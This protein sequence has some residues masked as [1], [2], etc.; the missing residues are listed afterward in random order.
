MSELVPVSAGADLALLAQDELAAAT[1]LAQNSIAESSKKVYDRDMKLFREWCTAR[2]LTALPADVTTVARYVAAMEATLAVS[3]IRR[4]LASISVHHQAAGHPTPTRDPAIGRVMDGLV[5]RHG[6]APKKVRAARTSVLR[7]LVA[8]LH[9]D[10][11]AD[12][13][14][15]ALLVVGMAGAF[16][17]SEL[18]AID[19]EHVTEDE[20]G[21]RI[22]VLRSKRDQEGKG[23]LV[24]VPYGS[25]PETCPVRSWRA[26]LV[27]SGIDSGPAFRAVDKHG[28]LSPTRI[29][30]RQVARIV[31]RRALAVG[32]PAADFAGHSLRAGYATEAYA[33]GKSELSIMR[34]GRCNTHTAMEGY[35]QEGGLWTDNAAMGLG[36]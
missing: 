32:L 33:A 12:I 11:L 29:T 21:L 26:W 30:D 35:V 34:G 2:D 4:R 23:A 8:P 28:H 18:V 1:D 36:L 25:N 22:R 6:V 5:R 19:V 10:R 16:R 27:A 7:S 20:Q 14:D 24:G 17:R 3:T 15:R 13:R 9:P 31:Q